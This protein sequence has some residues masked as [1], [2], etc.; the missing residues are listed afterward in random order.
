[1]FSHTA[2]GKSLGVPVE[3]NIYGKYNTS[4]QMEAILPKTISAVTGSSR[5]YREIFP[6]FIIVTLEILLLNFFNV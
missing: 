4:S 5:F 1:M 2:F 6:C 3:K